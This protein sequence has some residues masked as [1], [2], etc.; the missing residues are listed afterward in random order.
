MANPYISRIATFRQVCMV[1]GSR[2]SNNK[3][4][5]LLLCAYPCDPTKVTKYYTHLHTAGTCPPNKR[6]GIAIHTKCLPRPLDSIPD[7]LDTW[8]LRLL[9]GDMEVLNKGLAGGGGV[10]MVRDL[11]KEN[12]HAHAQKGK[13]I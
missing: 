11:H 7:A 9:F 10:Q 3:V 6:C 13:S 4:G 5:D 8:A 12:A 1:C 2:R